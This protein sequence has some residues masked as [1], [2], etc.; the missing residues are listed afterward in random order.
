MDRE[1]LEKRKKDLNAYLQVSHYVFVVVF[2]VVIL[3][4]EVDKKQLCCRWYTIL[5]IIL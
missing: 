3:F 2:L 4:T 1:F 5:N